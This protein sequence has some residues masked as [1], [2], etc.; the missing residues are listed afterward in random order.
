MPGQLVGFSIP[1]TPENS[2]GWGPTTVPDELKDIPFAP[3]SKGDKLGR[4]S[5]FTSQGFNKQYGA[6]IDVV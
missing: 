3:F 5:D 1:Q 2:E 4:V 6:G